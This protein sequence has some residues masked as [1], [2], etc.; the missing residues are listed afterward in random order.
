MRTP[1][2]Q[3]FGSIAT[4]VVVLSCGLLGGTTL[5]EK[6]DQ[7]RLEAEQA[8]DRSWVRSVARGLDNEFVATEP[9]V[10]SDRV[11][12]GT[13][14]SASMVTL[15]EDG[16]LQATAMKLVA[17]SGYN[18]DIYFALAVD[19]KDTIIGLKI[20]SHEETPGFG[21]V[22]SN[23]DSEWIVS[24]LGRSLQN[25]KPSRWQLRT[26]GGDIDGITGA[27][28]TASAVIAGISRALHYIDQEN[29]SVH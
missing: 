2:T 28:I 23:A 13:A 10:F 12:L 19:E 17:P 18:G 16:V 29:A 1:Q 11:R 3:F 5:G 24:F 14:N 27:T 4:I 22:I 6:L 25:P 8:R 26:D 21:D 15:L 9:V 7:A 20:L